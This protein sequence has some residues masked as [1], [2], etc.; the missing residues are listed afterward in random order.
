MARFS[1]AVAWLSLND[2]H[3]S[4]AVQDVAGYVTTVLVAD[5]FG[6][7][8]EAVARAVLTD[9]LRRGAIKKIVE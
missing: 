4:D 8:P 1:D 2:D 7:S 6:T 5:L 9:R 3:S